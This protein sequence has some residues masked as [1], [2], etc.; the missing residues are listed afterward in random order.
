VTPGEIALPQG[1]LETGWWGPG[2][3]AAPTLVLL[4]E[5]LGSLGLW[6]DFPAQLA[7][8][9]GC[10]VF[11]YSR[12]GYGN[13]DSVTLPRPLDFMRIEADEI[14]PAVLDRI[15]M[16]RGVLFGHSDGGSIA[17]IY[18]GSRQD[19]R[20]HGLVL[21]APRFFTEEAGLAAIAATRERFESG[22]LR[23]RLARHHRDVDVAFRGWA[24]AWL[25]PRFPREFDLCSDIAHIR[26]PILAIQG[27]A[28][29]YGTAE[30]LHVLAREAYCPVRTVFLPG[31]DH[32]P[33][34]EAT[35]AV[36]DAVRRFTAKLWGSG[37]AA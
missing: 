8:A 32:A 35:Q 31:V 22:D 7:Q 37:E 36:L 34:L 10:G 19:F 27:E 33:H 23:P 28:D 21:V 2:P 11:A 16:R 15:G 1:R 3:E 12:L 6:R 20:I 17:A 14:L 13:S 4:H 5:G 25:D 18:A 9:T 29:S 30:Q 26:V 24:G